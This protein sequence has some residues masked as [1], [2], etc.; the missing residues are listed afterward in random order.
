MVALIPVGYADGIPFNFAG[1]G[2]V[3]IKNKSSRVT[4][5]CAHIKHTYNNDRYYAYRLSKSNHVIEIY[6]TMLRLFRVSY[7]GGI[8][9]KF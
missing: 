9:Y 1:G 6:I 3:Y 5:L 8:K 4:V 2:K 7:S